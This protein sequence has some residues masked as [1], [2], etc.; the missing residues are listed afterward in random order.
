MRAG[1]N[2]VRPAQAHYDEMA[3]FAVAVAK[4]YPE[5]AGIEVWNEPNYPRFWGGWP[6]PDLYAKMLKEVAGA[7]HAGVPGM[8]VVSGGLSPHS[9]SDKHAIGFTNFLERLYELG[10]AQEADAI[11]IHPYPGVG[12]SEDY[13]ADVRVYLGKIRT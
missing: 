12:P 8:P 9:D 5:S 2:Q 3:T 13:V 10:A 11:G 4:R 7:L 6:E 1:D